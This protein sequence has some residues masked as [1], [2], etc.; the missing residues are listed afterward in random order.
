MINMVKMAYLDTM[1][2]HTD[3]VAM[4][5]MILILDLF[6]AHRMKFSENFSVLIHHLLSCSI[7]V[8]GSIILIFYSTFI[9]IF[10]I[11]KN[12]TDFGQMGGNR[13]N[14]NRH[15]HPQNSTLLTSFMNPFMGVSLMDD[16]FS[17]NPSA[18]GFSS[19]SSMSFSN[20]SGNGAMKR[21]STSTT[22]ANGKK[23]MT[24]KWVTFCLNTHTISFISFNFLIFFS[25]FFAESTKMVKKPFW[26][27]KTMC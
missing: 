1:N 21:T 20:G 24:R 13:R 16:F 10:F 4:I 2:V 19:I 6:S 17:P 12:N 18:N 26:N 22:F 9:I 23:L 15:S 25:L 7:T 8:N 3:L 14:G 5:M 11:W 27:M